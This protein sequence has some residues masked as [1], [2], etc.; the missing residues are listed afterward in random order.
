MR[1]SGWPLVLAL[2]LLVWTPVN[3]ALSASRLI[4]RLTLRGPGLGMI[5]MA[6]LVVAGIAVAAGLALLGRRPAAVGLAKMALVG[7][8]LLEIV[9]YVSPSYPHNRPPADAAL[10][11]VASLAYY[12]AWFAYLSLSKRVAALYR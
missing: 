1:I 3:L 2:L 8:A 6:Q 7:A 4:D 5:L 9:T 11:L 10:V 12:A